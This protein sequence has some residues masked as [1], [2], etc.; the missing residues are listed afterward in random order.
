MEQHIL[1]VNAHD[2]AKFE[3][4]PVSCQLTGH[5]EN[6]FLYFSVY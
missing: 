6:E 3:S 5:W 1:N 2:E 4:G